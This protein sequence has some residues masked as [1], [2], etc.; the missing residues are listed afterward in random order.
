MNN[1]YNTMELENKIDRIAE[2]NEGEVP[3]ALFNELMAEQMKSIVQIE[4]LVQYIRQLDL[5]VEMCNAEITRIDTMKNKAKKRIE[6][7]ESYITPY[8]KEHHKVKAGTF[9]L[10]IRKSKSVK[11][12][13]KSQIPLVYMHEIPVELQPDKN[14]IK[15]D[16][17][18]GI[19]VPGAELQ[20]NNNLQIK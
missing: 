17:K 10:S 19:C 2:L 18:S 15:K 12:K 7:I 9:T 13:D 4:N 1:L 11:I 6:S 3:E 20:E 14:M 16:L 8:V 5:G